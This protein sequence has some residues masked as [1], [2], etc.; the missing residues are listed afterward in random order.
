LKTAGSHREIQK[1]DLTDVDAMATYLP[2][3][4]VYGAE[5]FIANVARSLKVPERFDR[6]LFDA[7]KEGV[8]QLIEY[9]RQ[10]LANRPPVNV[11]A[12]SIFVAPADGI[13]QHSFEF[14]RMIGSQAKRAEIEL[15]DWV[16]VFGFDDGRMP[17]YEMRRPPGARE[18]FFGYQ[19][20]NVVDCTL[21][22]GA[23]AL[24]EAA[25]KECRST[26]FLLV[27]SYQDLPD[28]FVLR[29]LFA[30]DG[31]SSVLGYRI[32]RRDG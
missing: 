31:S 32:Y 16:E 27:D 5:R 20:V 15:D 3:C 7:T 28:D 9:L 8:K 2:Y 24:I 21:S 11:P 13:K 22:K 30:V 25:R 1:G 19:E 23:A 12:L 26:H 17:Q 14:F 6:Q 18:P 10:A 29:A 4:D